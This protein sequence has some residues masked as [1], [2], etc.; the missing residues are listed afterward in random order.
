MIIL[1][2][3]I[4]FGSEDSMTAINF[5]NAQSEP[6]SMLAVKVAS[7]DKTTTRVFYEIIL[8]RFIL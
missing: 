4:P 1:A 2:F 5:V 6:I 3:G 8:K 7:P